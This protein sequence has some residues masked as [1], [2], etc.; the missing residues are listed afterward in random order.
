MENAQPYVTRSRE[1]VQK[2]ID[3]WK[4]SGKNKTVFCREQNI[5]YLTFIGWT[6]PKRK[7]SKPVAPSGFVPLKFTENRTSAHENIFAE[8]N[9]RNGSS[10][11]IH[12][13]VSSGFLRNL[14]R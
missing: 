11:K 12:S 8:I 14:L 6:N 2:L 3:Q 9:F 1:E 10:V 13:S 4:Q 5:K 7:K